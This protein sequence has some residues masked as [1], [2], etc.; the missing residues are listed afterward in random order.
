MIKRCIGYQV[1]PD[2]YHCLHHYA[3]SAWP[4]STAPKMAVKTLIAH[5]ECCWS[6]NRCL[7]HN[8]ILAIMKYQQFVNSFTHPLQHED[9]TPLLRLLSVHGKAAKGIADTVGAIDVGRLYPKR[10][11]MLIL[12]DVN[13][14]ND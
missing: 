1:E 2:S 5:Y 14:R 6:S 8:Q 11:D 7:P 13:R 9:P 4:A 12:M 3:Q 10:K